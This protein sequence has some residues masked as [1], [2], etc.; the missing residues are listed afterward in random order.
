MYFLCHCCSL[1]LSARLLVN[2][3]NS[4]VIF[5]YWL[6]FGWGLGR[7]ATGLRLEFTCPVEVGGVVVINASSTYD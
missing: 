5:E 6:Y 7:T 1:D 3:E 2:P 4:I